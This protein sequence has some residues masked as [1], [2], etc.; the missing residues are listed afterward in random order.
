MCVVGLLVM[1]VSP[2]Y[3]RLFLYTCQLYAVLL[4]SKLRTNLCKA[5]ILSLNDILQAVAE[6]SGQ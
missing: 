2:R 1:G 5:N 4:Q 3:K 6:C